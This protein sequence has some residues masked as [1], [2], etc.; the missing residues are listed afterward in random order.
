MV[1]VL[2]VCLSFVMPAVCCAALSTAMLVA[3]QGAARSRR[4]LTL[5]QMHT[6]L[7]TLPYKRLFMAAAA[8]AA[9]APATFQLAAARLP[10]GGSSI[11]E[12]CATLAGQVRENIALRRGFLIRA[13]EHGET[14]GSAQAVESLLNHC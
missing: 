9:A 4:Q 11:E 14:A 7:L 10:E 1:G 8:A 5:Q 2:F 12:A 13:A 6:R 3:G